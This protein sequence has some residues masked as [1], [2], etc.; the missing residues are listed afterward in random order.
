VEASRESSEAARL[1][2]VFREEDLRAER[3]KFENG[4]STTFLVLSKQNDLD[5]SIAAEL[6]AQIT[7][8]KSITALEQATGHLLEAR[9][10]TGIK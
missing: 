10:F 6:Q 2:R 7:F 4:L 9:G 1:T 3:K 5:A 8:A